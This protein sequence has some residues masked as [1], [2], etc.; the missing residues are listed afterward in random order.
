M[1]SSLSVV[2]VERYK[3]STIVCPILSL[4]L[5]ITRSLAQFSLITIVLSQTLG[6]FSFDS[7][8]LIYSVHFPKCQRDKVL[9]VKVA[10]PVTEA[11]TRTTRTVPT[12]KAITIAVV[13]YGSSASNQNSYHYSNSNGSYYYSNPNGSTYYNDGQGGS[14]Y[15]PSSGNKK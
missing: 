10:R 14:T 12:V 7:H 3:R 5:L 4:H 1:T 13:I 8:Y 15:T 6:I 11:A 9:L 2:G